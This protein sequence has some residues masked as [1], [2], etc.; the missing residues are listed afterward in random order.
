M[1]MVEP[2]GTSRSRFLITCGVSGRYW[3]VTFSN[4][5]LP[6]SGLRTPPPAGSTGVFITTPSIRTESATCWYSWISPTSRTSGPVTRP[7]SIWNA[8]SAPMLSTWSNT[9]DAPSQI[10]ETVI[11]ISS[12]W[13]MVRAVIE[14][15]PTR[16]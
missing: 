13:L 15:L 10:T 4:E 1:P 9:S 11:S 3:K 16:K 14:I 2:T 12:I 5:I 6:L 7:E 8:I